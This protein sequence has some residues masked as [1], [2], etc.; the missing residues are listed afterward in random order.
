MNLGIEDLQAVALVVDPVA[1]LHA[2]SGHDLPW[3]Q[4]L[5]TGLLSTDLALILE[6]HFSPPPP[7]PLSHL[8]RRIRRRSSR[9]SFHCAAA[10]FNL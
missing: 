1:S 10:A 4:V 6:V 9:C 5:W 8:A 3:G 7:S 2:I